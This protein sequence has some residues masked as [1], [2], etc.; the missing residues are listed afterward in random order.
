[1]VCPFCQAEETSVVDSRKNSEGTSIRRRRSCIS[2]KTRFTTY[3]KAS[4]GLIVVKRNGNREEFNIDKLYSGVKNAFGGQEPCQATLL[5]E[6]HDIGGQ[7]PFQ[8]HIP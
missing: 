1:M 8:R 7:E 6:G 2:C 4:I 5:Q 3:E